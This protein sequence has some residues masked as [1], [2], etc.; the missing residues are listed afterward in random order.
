MQ[1]KALLKSFFIFLFMGISLPAFS[2]NPFDKELNA[3]KAIVFIIDGAENTQSEQ[4]A[5]WSHYLNQFSSDN[6]KTYVFHKIS[7]DKL[8]G[9]IH[10]ADKYNTPYSMIFMK[11]GKPDYFYE[12][13]VI[14]PQIYRFI[15]LTYEG[16]PV[17]PEYLLQY[18]PD[19]VSIKFKKCD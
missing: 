17:K 12:G 2:C 8:K 3:G 5:D 7:K 10:N 4:Y 13:P 16:K 18:A 1:K 6:T 9:I 11:N 14:E 19:K 15:E